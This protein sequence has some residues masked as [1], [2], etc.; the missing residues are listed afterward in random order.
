[1]NV[2]NEKNLWLLA[3]AGYAGAVLYYAE[4]FCSIFRDMRVLAIIF[5]LVLIMFVYVFTY[6][7]YEAK[8]VMP[9][10]FRNCLCGSN[11]VITFI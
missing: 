10:L 8:Q 3:A 4:L 5:G 6:P 9:T 7:E 11:A 1:M 2:Q